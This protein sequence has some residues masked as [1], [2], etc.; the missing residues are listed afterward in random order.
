MIN[1]IPSE[2]DL[3]QLANS[4]FPDFDGQAPAGYGFDPQHCAEGIESLVTTG[5]T[6]VISEALQKAENYAG[7]YGDY[8]QL[9][10]SFV[11]G[12]YPEYENLAN[13]LMNEAAAAETA[14]APAQVKPAKVL[15][16]SPKKSA[17]LPPNLKL[18]PN[19]FANAS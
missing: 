11:G 9:A 1:G 13:E 18:Q 5:D 4:L 6:S 14:S 7:S 17:N 3:E 19:K 8:E 15:P 10:N 2:H 12:L 16:S